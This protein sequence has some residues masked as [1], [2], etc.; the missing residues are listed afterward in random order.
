MNINGTSF[1][2]KDD[3]SSSYNYDKEK[4]NSEQK[5]QNPFEK[6]LRLKNLLKN[7]LEESAI[8]LGNIGYGL[9]NTE[10][11]GKGN[12]FKLFGFNRPGKESESNSI[13][14]PIDIRDMER[15]NTQVDQDFSKDISS[16]DEKL[17]K[18]FGIVLSISRT[19]RIHSEQYTDSIELNDPDIEKS[20][21]TGDIKTVRYVVNSDDERDESDDE[22]KTHRAQKNPL[23][24]NHTTYSA[25]KD[26]G[27]N[28][29]SLNP[30]S[31]RVVNC[32]KEASIFSTQD[33]RKVIQNSSFKHRNS[34]YIVDLNEEEVNNLPVVPEKNENCESRVFNNENHQ[35]F[36]INDDPLNAHNNKIRN[37]VYN[38]VR[39]SV[40]QHSTLDDI[41]RNNSSKQPYLPQGYYPTVSVEQSSD[42]NLG[43]RNKKDCSKIDKERGYEI[44]LNQIYIDKRTNMMIR[45]IPNRYKREMML[46]MIDADFCNAYD[47]F[48][49]PM[50]KGNNCNLGYAF[51]NFVDLKHV[52]PFY[53]KFNNSTWKKYN[54]GKICQITYAQ[55]QNVKN[56]FKYSSPMDG[57]NELVI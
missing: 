44:I 51:I 53:K 2:G 46:E 22:F 56:C 1:K 28:P 6:D 38:E 4:K 16:G 31:A 20:M 18:A 30:G 52:E 24:R 41:P 8:R 27:F 9:L 32:N 21:N 47:F 40:A 50:D 36:E 34:I 17:S 49:L 12:N 19:A 15:L 39:R 26:K 54:S 37:N 23:T 35:I 55:I 13:D 10:I 57:K 29:K 5:Y 14:K 42:K 45:N 25:I 48:Y 11:K 43:P 7:K 3:P 33:S